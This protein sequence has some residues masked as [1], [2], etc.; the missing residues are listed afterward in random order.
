[1][2]CDSQL[3]HNL[4]KHRDN[5][6]MFARLRNGT[7]LRITFIVLEIFLIVTIISVNILISRWYVSSNNLFIHY[8]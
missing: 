8:L 6:K 1:M 7:E 3:Q 5:L 4:W 2:K